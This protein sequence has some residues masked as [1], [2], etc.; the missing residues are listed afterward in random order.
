ML[1]DRYIVLN[2]KMIPYFFC[3]DARCVG[4]NDQKTFPDFCMPN[5]VERRE[6]GHQET[7]EIF[8]FPDSIVEEIAKPLL[9]N[10]Q[11]A[12][13]TDKRQF[14]GMELLVDLHI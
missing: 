7:D 3:V 1:A 11:I 6:G 8:K 12:K 13:G 10:H 2:C 5:N 9:K 14:A 4:M